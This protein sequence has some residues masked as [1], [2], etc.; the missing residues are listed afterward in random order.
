M[1]GGVAGRG[2]RVAWRSGVG[3]GRAWR[4]SALV[5]ESVQQLGA[6]GGCPAVDAAEG[7]PG[8][9][10]AAE[11]GREALRVGAVAEVAWFGFGFAFGFGFGFGVGVGVGVGEG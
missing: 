2:R 8:L 4:A 7:R 11:D 5:A 10:G 1:G 9:K 3:R 6:A